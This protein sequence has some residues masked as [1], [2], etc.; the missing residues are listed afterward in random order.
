MECYL[1]ESVYCCERR[2]IESHWDWW[3]C[4]DESTCSSNIHTVNNVLRCKMDYVGRIVGE[5][6]STVINQQVS[7][8]IWLM[9]PLPILKTYQYDFKTWILSWLWNFPLLFCSPL[10]YYSIQAQCDK[11][12]S[13]LCIQ[14]MPIAVYCCWISKAFRWQFSWVGYITVQIHRTNSPTI[15]MHPWEIKF[16]QIPYCIY[17]SEDSA[18]HSLFWSVSYFATNIHQQF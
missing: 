3:F 15:V 6:C 12:E 5:K 4:W 11:F 13:R 14:S 18:T 16:C 17:S 9:I 1:C 2:A 10:Q 7:I 8:P